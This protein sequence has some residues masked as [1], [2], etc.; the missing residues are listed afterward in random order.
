MFT[1]TVHQ[2]RALTTQPSATRKIDP[3]T[4]AGGEKEND[5][6]EDIY[7]FL[8]LR[9]MENRADPVIDDVESR[10]QTK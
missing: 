8:K 9:E 4:F 6:S 7:I 3:P 2:H 10:A 5:D 1:K